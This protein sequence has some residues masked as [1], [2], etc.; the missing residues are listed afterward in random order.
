MTLGVIYYTGIQGSE[1]YS[2]IDAVYFST[3]T[4]MTIGIYN[5]HFILYLVNIVT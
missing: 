4:L 2:F 3:A 1:G 5:I